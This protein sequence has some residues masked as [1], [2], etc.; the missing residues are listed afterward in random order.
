MQFAHAGR[1][2]KDA[3]ASVIFAAVAHGVVMAAGQQ[4]FDAWR[5]GAINTDHIAHRVDAHLVKAAVLHR[6]N[7]RC[8]AG[9]MRVGEVS[10]GELV[11]F[12]IFRVAEL[13]Q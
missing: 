12:Q 5:V 7:D 9:A 1:G 11:F 8:G 13:R 6:A 3:E 10:D 2:H 4:G